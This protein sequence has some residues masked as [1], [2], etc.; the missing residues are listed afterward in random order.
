MEIKNCACLKQIR[1]FAPETNS[2]CHGALKDCT[3][4][5]RINGRRKL[6]VGDAGASSFLFLEEEMECMMR[7][8]DVFQ[9]GEFF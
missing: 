7:R 5:A 4:L 9:G 3:V 6:I 1:R 2:P 8:F